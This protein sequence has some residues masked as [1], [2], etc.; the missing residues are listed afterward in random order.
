MWARRCWVVLWVLGR[1]K[2]SQSLVGAPPNFSFTGSESGFQNIFRGSHTSIRCPNSAHRWSSFFIGRL[3][4]SLKSPRPFS[5]PLFVVDTIFKLAMVPFHSGFGHG[6]LFCSLTFSLL[7]LETRGMTPKKSSFCSAKRGWNDESG[8]KVVD[9]R[10]EI[11]NFRS[12][13]ARWRA[14]LFLLSSGCNSYSFWARVFVST[15]SKHVFPVSLRGSE[16]MNHT[17]KEFLAGA[18]FWREL[19]RSKAKKERRRIWR[20]MWKRF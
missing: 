15:H 19:L 20:R 10:I 16:K 13:G 14:I 8:E 11:S 9:A 3:T 18:D 4:R 7:I 2:M 1:H 5:L 6:L 12:L 17:L